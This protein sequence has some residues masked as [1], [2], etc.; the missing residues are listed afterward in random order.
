M[1]NALENVKSE[2]SQAR[3]NEKT[4]INLPPEDNYSTIAE[5]IKNAYEKNFPT[6]KKRFR[7]DR[8]KINEWMTDSILER[9]KA[10]DAL[11]NKIRKS[12][13]DDENLKQ[14]KNQ[15]REAVREINFAIRIAKKVYYTRQ[16]EKFKSD[17]KKTWGT[18]SEIMNKRRNKT[19]YP[20]F[21]E[22]DGKKISE[23]KDIANEFNSYFSSIGQKLANEI[24]TTGIPTVDSYLGTELQK[25]KKCLG[26]F[27]RTFWR[28][29]QNFG[30]PHN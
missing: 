2:V 19:K 24:N 3:L 26:R 16:I 5:T 23:K 4:S 6:V 28:P 25:A 13:C 7:R 17:S 30:A 22:V 18:I 21:F 9:I 8:H 15:L 11:Y 14:F 27:F 10:K 20:P 1:D 29:L 12:K